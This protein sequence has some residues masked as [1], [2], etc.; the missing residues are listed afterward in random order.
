MAR[1][2]TTS[3]PPPT[4]KEDKR[5]SAPFARLA[6]PNAPRTVERRGGCVE[7]RGRFMG[8]GVTGGRG[9]GTCGIFGLNNSTGS[10]SLAPN[11]HPTDIRERSE[12]KESTTSERSERVQIVLI[13]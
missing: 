10:P 3:L 9:K 1:A 13:D 12:R 5:H 2:A 7:K 8:K 11:E 6:G 4:D